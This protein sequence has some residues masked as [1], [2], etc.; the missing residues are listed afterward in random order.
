MIRK[1]IAVILT[2]ILAFYSLNSTAFAFIDE[3]PYN[4]RLLERNGCYTTGDMQSVRGIMIHSTGWNNPHLRAYVGPDD[5]VLGGGANNNAWNVPYP[6]GREVAVHGFIGLDASGNV[7]AYQTLPWEMVGWH[8][9]AANGASDLSANRNGYIGVEMCE[10]SLN[11]RAYFLTVY[12]KMVEL[13]AYLCIEYKFKPEY[14]YIIG[15]HEGYL[16]GIASN[17]A[18]PDHWF[19]RHGKSM[20]TFRS[21]VKARVN[22]LI[23]VQP[24]SGTI[25]IQVGGNDSKSYDCLYIKG[26]YVKLDTALEILEADPSW[27]SIASKT[28]N[29]N[30]LTLDALYVLGKKTYVDVC[31]I[32]GE[33]YANLR[34]SAQALDASATVDDSGAWRIEINSRTIA[35]PISRNTVRRSV[36]SSGIASGTATAYTVFK[37]NNE[38]Y[39]KLRDIA[40]LWHNTRAEFSVS[41]VSGTLAI[42]LGEP[43]HPI[44]SELRKRYFTG[45]VFAKQV[46]DTMFV[47]GSQVHFTTYLIEGNAYYR[48]TDLEHIFGVVSAVSSVTGI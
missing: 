43:Y 31:Y 34:Q 38:D 47:N 39:Y 10:D 41:S 9:G 21:D 23:R 27:V 19:T 29:N 15:H 35:I 6:G 12:S 48:I 1:L 45:S 25:D 28:P 37:I 13:A 32:D 11:N 40:E 46:I 8:A 30:E 3:E 44:G 20:N 7:R 22:E 18:D 2:A 24:Q 17:H 14:P 26:T 5:G 4:V 16:V 33:P 42:R 36:S